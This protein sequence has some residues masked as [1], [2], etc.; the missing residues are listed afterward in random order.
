VTSTPLVEP[1]TAV[2]MATLSADISLLNASLASTTLTSVTSSGATLA[3]TGATP[4]AQGP[5]ADGAAGASILQALQKD[6]EV[7][8]EHYWH[9]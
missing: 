2:S 1:R 3:A 5:A 4:G 9:V 8:P 7:F 6:R